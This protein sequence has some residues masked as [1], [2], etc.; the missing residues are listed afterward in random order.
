[1]PQ[2]PKMGQTNG[3]RHVLPNDLEEGRR[4]LSES[5]LPSGET[6]V[7]V[8]NNTVI[9]YFR[10]KV[11]VLSVLQ[12]ARYKNSVPLLCF[13]TPYYKFHI[14]QIRQTW[15]PICCGVLSGFVSCW[16]KH[17]SLYPTNAY[18]SA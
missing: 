3:D 4:H 14:K 2:P 9:G 11:F 10:I 8:V 13:P 5:V 1:M 7:T 15:I 6:L 18:T 16:Y 17:T 12:R